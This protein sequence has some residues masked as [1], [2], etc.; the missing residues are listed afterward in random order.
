MELKKDHYD[1]LPSMACEILDRFIQKYSSNDWFE[2]AWAEYRSYVLE[3]EMMSLK[4]PY[5]IFKNYIEKDGTPKKVLKH[6]GIKG[7]RWGVRRFQNKEGEK[8][9]LS[10]KQ[11]DSIKTAG[12]VVGAAVAGAAAVGAVWYLKNVKTKKILRQK[13]L[14]S[15]AKGA[16][17]RAARKASGAYE[18]FKNVD[19]FITNGSDFVKSF[20]NVK[21]AKILA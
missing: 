18:V 19:V 6:F 11:K 21:V 8:R 15:A 12:I 16:A 4:M 10:N 7:Q 20:S 13:R 1:K 2:D 17:T 9:H 3:T 5:Y 14:A